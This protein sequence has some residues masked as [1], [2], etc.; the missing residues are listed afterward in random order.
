MSKQLGLVQ[1]SLIGCLGAAIAAFCFAHVDDPKGSTPHPTYTGPGWCIGSC[2]AEGGIAGGPA[3]LG[4]QS[5]LV[6]QI[7]DAF[8]KVTENLDAL[9]RY[10]QSQRE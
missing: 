1:A 9:R 10:Q 6:H 7:L 2:G 8:H 3:W 4:D 5:R